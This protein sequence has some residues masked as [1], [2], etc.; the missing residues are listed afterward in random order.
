M[1]R[2]GLNTWDEQSKR[3]SLP[4]SMSLQGGTASF[5]STPPMG[6]LKEERLIEADTPTVMGRDMRVLGDLRG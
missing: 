5:T 1:P 4:P 3:I 2:R 6:G